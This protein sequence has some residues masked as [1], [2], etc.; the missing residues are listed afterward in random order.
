MSTSTESGEATGMGGG[1]RRFE[2]GDGS[3][4]GRAARWAVVAMAGATLAVVL[5]TS[6]DGG[7]GG[8]SAPIT[9]TVTTPSGTPTLTLPGPGPGPVPFETSAALGRPVIR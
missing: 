6:G 2:G 8:R 4:G 7:S 1:H 9:V 5:L 3:A